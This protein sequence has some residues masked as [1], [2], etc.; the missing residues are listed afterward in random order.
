[1]VF[2]LHFS[3]FVPQV[4]QI[5]KTSEKGNSCV[6][7]AATN[8]PRVLNSCDRRVIADVIINYLHR[9]ACKGATVIPHFSYKELQ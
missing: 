5:L 9:E 1:M 8:R 4:T 6:A 7:L 3:L 2:M